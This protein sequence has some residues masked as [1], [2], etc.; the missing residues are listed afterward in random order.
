MVDYPG[1]VWVPAA[2]FTSPRQG[3]VDKLVLHWM[4]TT[5]AGADA[6]FSGGIRQASAHYGVEDATV[7]QYVLEADAAWHA[8][9]RAVNHASIGIEHSAAP[10]RPASEATIATSIALCTHLCRKY[11]IDPAT[12]I[13]RHSEYVAT[14]C[15]GTL[16]VDRI[17]TAVAAALTTPAAAK[18]TAVQAI[19]PLEA[20]VKIVTAAPSASSPTGE[21]GQFLVT[22]HGVTHLNTP[23]ESYVVARVLAATDGDFLLQRELDVYA[24]V[25]ARVK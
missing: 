21:R 24:A 10:G 15:P 3:R 6:T 7:H 5:L 9:N 18:T 2:Y 14:Q 22:P 23:E 8:A 16:P 25:V 19:P 4:A 17:K 12:G 1:A 13:H 11:R 20:Q